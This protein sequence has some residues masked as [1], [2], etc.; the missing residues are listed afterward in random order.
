M[1]IQHLR[2]RI[3]ILE[4]SMAMTCPVEYTTLFISESQTLSTELTESL[5]E[6][7]KLLA[8]PQVKHPMLNSGVAVNNT[9][10]VA[11]KIPT[12]FASSS[13]PDHRL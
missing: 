11:R 12:A 7:E 2:Q 1:A 3:H 13:T 10:I 6:L 9:S 5:C 8:N 4:A